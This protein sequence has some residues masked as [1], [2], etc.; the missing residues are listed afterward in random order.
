MPPIATSPLPFRSSTSSS[1]SPTPSP[2]KLPRS[3]PCIRPKPGSKAA[4]RLAKVHVPPEALI[5]KTWPPRPKIPSRTTP[6]IDFNEPWTP[7]LTNLTF[8]WKKTRYP[9]FDVGRWG[10][11][12]G[13]LEGRANPFYVYLERMQPADL[14]PEQGEAEVLKYKVDKTIGVGGYSHVFRLTA[15]DPANP[16]QTLAMKVPRGRREPSFR[17][18]TALNREIAVARWLSDPRT[19]DCYKDLFPAFY[20]F[21]ALNSNLTLAVFMEEMRC[22]LHD[23]LVKMD[24][25]DRQA[26]PPFA[27]LD[28]AAGTGQVLQGSQSLEYRIAMC[29]EVVKKISL[30]HECFIDM[31]GQMVIH[32]DLKADNLLIDRKGHI[33]IADLGILMTVKDIDRGKLPLGTPEYQAPEVI[34]KLGVADYGD[35]WLQRM[36][37]LRWVQGRNN[38]PMDADCVIWTIGSILLTII[39]PALLHHPWHERGLECLPKSLKARK[40]METS[41]SDYIA[42]HLP[43]PLPGGASYPIHMVHQVLQGCFRASGKRSSLNTL[44]NQFESLNA[45][46][47]PEFIAIEFVGTKLRRRVRFQAPPKTKIPDR[48]GPELDKDEVAPMLPLY[49]GTPPLSPDEAAEEES[50]GFDFLQCERDC[51][52]QVKADRLKDEMDL[53]DHRA[54]PDCP[55]IAYTH[56]AQS[57]HDRE[58]PGF[59]NVPSRDSS[60]EQI[61]RDE[62]SEGGGVVTP[63]DIVPN[64]YKHAK[65][66]A[67]DW[68]T[69]RAAKDE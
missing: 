16:L 13:T 57:D 5:P 32:S 58:H 21:R 40:M 65:A 25:L 7:D 46:Q 44:I 49:P 47:T 4:L 19:P 43:Q 61:E 52:E 39:H 38:E 8:V 14:P 42:C 9:S 30:M 31:F 51:Q 33:K 1:P 34:S 17:F 36:S 55:P 15:C 62:I 27:Y 35:H 11:T 53:L 69:S 3:F 50:V 54:R 56:I 59:N 41:L 66:Y 26:Y 45:G 48:D 68:W 10:C 18:I 29:L 60:W 67:S 24:T 28:A 2:V 22:N 37:S 6:Q 20:P 23:L 64:V 63:P 12:E